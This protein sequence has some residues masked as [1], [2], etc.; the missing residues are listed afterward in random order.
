MVTSATIVEPTATPAASEYEGTT[1]G[2]YATKESS[3][4]FPQQISAAVM[5]PSASVTT[6]N[7]N[8]EHSNPKKRGSG[9]NAFLVA[10]SKNAA[11]T[12]LA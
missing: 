7:N 9:I 4:S 8:R 6:P 1:R 11:R 12:E 5:A 2:A 10:E 3:H